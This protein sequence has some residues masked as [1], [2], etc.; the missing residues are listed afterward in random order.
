MTELSRYYL[1]CLTLLLLSAWV[2]LWVRATSVRT[3]A[4]QKYSIVAAMPIAIISQWWWS[5]PVEPLSLIP[6]WTAAE[7]VLVTTVAL[8]L[9][10]VIPRR[11]VRLNF[12]KNININWLAIG[13]TILA[14]VVANL[15]AEATGWPREIL[16]A[17]CLF[18][19]GVAGLYWTA[20]RW[21]ALKQLLV[22]A[23]IGL[24]IIVATGAVT[25]ALLPDPN[26]VKIGINLGYTLEQIYLLLAVAWSWP[27]IASI[28][29]G[30]PLTQ[31]P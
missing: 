24:I 2:L 10:A 22:A 13:A 7:L 21:L 16:I 28:W 23:G 14:V 25:A 3:R 4:W 26:G 6:A 17:T 12:Q 18:F 30:Q 31:Q 9:I 11:V 1:I 8:S 19:T 5:W 27:V 29:L 20:N 15:I